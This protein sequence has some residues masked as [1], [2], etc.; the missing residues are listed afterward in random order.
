MLQLVYTEYSHRK[1]GGGVELF[2][3]HIICIR[4]VNKQWLWIIIEV[5][6]HNYICTLD[7]FVAHA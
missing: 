6:D 7:Q 4:Q 2:C 3:D 5:D 1:E